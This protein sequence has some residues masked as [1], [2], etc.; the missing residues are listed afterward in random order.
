[1]EET[2]AAY[3]LMA[4]F[5]SPSFGQVKNVTNALRRAEAG[6]SLSLREFLD[7]AET[8]RAHPFPGGMES[9]LRRG[10]NLP[11]RSVFRP[12]AQ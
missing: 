1:M 4:Q 6:A 5:G 10:G 12:R 2:D 8:L 7:I 9:P 11:G 3:R